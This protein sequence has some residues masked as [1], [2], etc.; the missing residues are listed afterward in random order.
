MCVYILSRDTLIKQTVQNMIEAGFIL[1]N[2]AEMFTN[3]LLRLDPKDLLCAL[4][5]SHDLREQAPER[6]NFYPIDIDAISKN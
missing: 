6:I 1:P 5:E 2:E 4:L 3:Q